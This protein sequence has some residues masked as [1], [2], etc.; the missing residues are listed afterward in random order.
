MTTH[1]KDNNSIFLGA[2]P[3]PGETR[4]L[5]GGEVILTLNEEEV[6]A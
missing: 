2:A 5:K 6:S 3:V 1:R 4:A